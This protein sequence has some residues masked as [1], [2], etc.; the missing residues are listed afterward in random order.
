M[1]VDTFKKLDFLTDEVDDLTLS[2][3]CADMETEY[4]VFEGIQNLSFSENFD[5]DAN[6]G[7]EESG[8]NSM[9]FDIGDL[10][11]LMETECEVEK[12]L[13]ESTRFGP[14][15]NDEDLKSLVE[16]QENKNTKSNT[17]WAVNVFSKVGASRELG[18]LSS[19]T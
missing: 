5:F 4:Y 14:V 1:D 2:Q 18:I 10:S 15:V 8:L 3:I 11:S 7:L 12:E 19:F 13:K 6:E 9:E 17:K 16:N